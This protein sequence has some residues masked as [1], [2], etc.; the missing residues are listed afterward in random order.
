M[1]LNKKQKLDTLIEY[2]EQRLL[3][4]CHAKIKLKTIWHIFSSRF[5]AK[6]Y[7][8]LPN[9][10]YF[11]TYYPSERFVLQDISYFILGKEY[12]SDITLEELLQDLI[13][14]R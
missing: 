8:L 9:K 14:R 6:G 4:K 5:N 10:S 13:K 2:F 12:N 7:D 1:N 11:L 3:T